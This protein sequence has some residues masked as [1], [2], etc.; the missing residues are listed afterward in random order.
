MLAGNLC[1]CTGYAPIIKAATEATALAS[2]D[3]LTEDRESSNHL[4][5]SMIR[6]YQPL[7]M[8]WQRFFVGPKTR[9]IA[10]A[11][12]VGLWVTKGL[13]DV[14][15]AAFLGFAGDLAK[16]IDRDDH[17]EIGAMVSIETSSLG[18]KTKPFLCGFVAGMITRCARPRHWG[19][20]LQM[21]HPLGTIL[22]P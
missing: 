14:S 22:R 10:G 18:N 17:T 2:P 11:T 5:P 19:V 15:P 8:R 7:V 12:D 4:K 9:L 13:T 20:I 21:D 16:I 1:R 3:W 6:R